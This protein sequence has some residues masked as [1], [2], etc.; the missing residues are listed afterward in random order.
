VVKLSMTLDELDE[1][2]GAV[3]GEPNYDASRRKKE[4]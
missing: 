2:T 4:E 3:A 1:Y